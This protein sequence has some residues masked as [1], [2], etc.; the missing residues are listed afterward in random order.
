MRSF[1]LL[2]RRLSPAKM[3]LCGRADDKSPVP[4]GVRSLAWLGWRDW[5]DQLHHEA[6]S[7]LSV[8]AVIP[9]E[10]GLSS[11]HDQPRTEHCLAREHPP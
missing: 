4:R 10:M 9:V 7:T 3:T 8:T 11:S 1:M 5:R 2:F 6:R